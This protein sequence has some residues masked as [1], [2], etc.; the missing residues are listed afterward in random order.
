LDIAESFLQ[1][2]TQE[3]SD[4]REDRDKKHKK[5]KLVFETGVSV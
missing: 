5:K 4:A 2:T 3:G 1:D